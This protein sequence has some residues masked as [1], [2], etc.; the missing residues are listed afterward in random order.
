MCQE[1]G[2]AEGT[3]P[4]ALSREL[5]TPGTQLDAFLSLA[6]KPCPSWEGEHGHRCVQ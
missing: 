3:L 4:G 5:E 1:T 6:S 2:F